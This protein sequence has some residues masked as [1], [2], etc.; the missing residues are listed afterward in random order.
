MSLAERWRHWRRLAKSRL[1]YVRRREYA[2][3]EQ[4]YRAITDALGQG[5]PPCTDAAMSAMKPVN[6]LFGPE[7]VFFVTYAPAP[8]LK[9]HVVRHVEAWLD[10]G[11]QV[12]LVANTPLAPE[13]IVI[14][15]SL[16]TRLAGAYVRDNLGF[17]FAAWAHLHALL[18]ANLVGCERLLLT[19][20]SIVGPLRAGQLDAVIARVRS[21]HADVVGL[22]EYHAPRYHLQSFF[23]VFQHRAV[24]SKA[25]SGFMHEVKNLPSKDLVIDFYETVLSDRLARAGLELEALFP[26]MAGSAFESNDTSERWEELVDKGFPYVKT[27]MLE[28]H[29]NDPR[30]KALVPADVREGYEFAN[31][32]AAAR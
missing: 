4:R 30:M 2:K 31:S 3:L 14:E 11:W 28:K 19:N 25:V 15:P 6:G 26:S 16:L 27:S 23:L 12:V 24:Q 7:V 8:Q 17:D 9:Q 1:P 22:T 18:E 5:L 21:S 32:R 29:W 10:A 20:D 13:T